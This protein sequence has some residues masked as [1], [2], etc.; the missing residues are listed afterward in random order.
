MSTFHVPDIH[1]AACIRSLTGAVRDLDAQA[2]LQADLQ[3][4]QVIVQTAAT[5]AE[6]TAAFEEAGFSV[7]AA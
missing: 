5:D 4:K 7:E 6:V 3:T 1:C 2:T